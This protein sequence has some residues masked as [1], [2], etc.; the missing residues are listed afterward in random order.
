M[1]LCSTVQK[2]LSTT[3]SLASLPIPYLTPKANTHLPAGEGSTDR[4]KQSTPETKTTSNFS[5]FFQLPGPLPPAFHSPSRDS[6]KIETLFRCLAASFR[7]GEP[8]HEVENRAQ[9]HTYTQLGILGRLTSWR[10]VDNEQLSCGNQRPANVRR[11][12]WEG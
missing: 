9:T 2:C 6:H 4:A 3:V 11:C 7:L 10:S 12:R 5:S 8:A 1:R